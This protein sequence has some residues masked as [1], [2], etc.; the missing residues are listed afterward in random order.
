MNDLY[1]IRITHPT[2]G[3]EYRYDPD[4]DCFYRQHN[5]D[6][7]NAEWRAKYGWIVWCLILTAVTF[8]VCLATDSEFKAW[9]RSLPPV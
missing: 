6:D 2:N 5:Y 4:H 1:N 7:A 8:C 3:Q 9:I